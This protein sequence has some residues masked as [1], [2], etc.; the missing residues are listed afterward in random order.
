[1]EER[2]PEPVEDAARPRPRLAFA[3]GVVVGFC[4]ATLP[5]FFLAFFGLKDGPQVRRLGWAAFL[6][7][8]ELALFAASLRI[9]R[10]GSR[11][12]WLQGALVGFAPGALVGGAVAFLL[13]AACTGLQFPPR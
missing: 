8:A 6:L 5:G 3:F 10:R 2:P 9:L 1:M 7:V 13:A 12:G 11:R 4:A